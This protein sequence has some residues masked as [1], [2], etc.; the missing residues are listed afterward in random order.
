MVPSPCIRDCRMDESSGLCLG[1]ARTR[2]EIATWKDESDEERRRIWLELPA[3]RASLGL[4]THRLAWT[5]D[6][7]RSFILSTLRPVGGTWVSGV[8]GAVAEFCICDDD[9]V[10]FGETEPFVKASTPRGAI[11]FQLSGHVNAFSIGV[12]PNPAASDVIVL[13]VL[14]EQAASCAWRGLACAAQD[15]EAIRPEDR[16]DVLYD[17]GLG[18]AAAGFGIRTADLD[19]MTSLDKLIGQTYSAFLPSIGADILRVSPIQL[20]ESKCSR[21]FHCRADDLPLARIRISCRSISP[22][23]ATCRRIFR[24]RKPM[25]RA[26]SIIQRR[27]KQISHAQDRTCVYFSGLRSRYVSMIQPFFR[28][29]CSRII[30]MS[31]ITSESLPATRTSSSVSR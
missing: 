29:A 5:T 8:Y 3:R 12:T 15:V 22:L 10:A 19:L 17:F 13:A 28:L 25:S 2:S 31:P 4:K 20:D 27:A 24:Y 14:R 18:S 30:S 23:A 6:E 26:S 11:A 16:Q 9:D 7:L 1:C 21:Q